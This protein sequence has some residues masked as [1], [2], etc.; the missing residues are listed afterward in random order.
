MKKINYFISLVFMMIT[1]LLNRH[2]NQ[3]MAQPG[4]TDQPNKDIRLV[5]ADGG[6]RMRALPSLKGSVVIL[7]PKDSTV[8]VLE[9]NDKQVNIGGRIGYW[10]KV[11]WK[12]KTGWVFGGF[13][14][15]IDHL[16]DEQSRIIEAMSVSF[17]QI[18]EKTLVTNYKKGSSEGI[19]LRLDEKNFSVGCSAYAGSVSLSGLVK[20]LP[21]P[22]IS[23]QVYRA[24]FSSSDH[25]DVVRGLAKD[26]TVTIQRKDGK[27][28]IDSDI[29]VC[30]GPW[31]EV[32]FTITP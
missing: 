21:A 2:E 14:A 5:V 31:N 4:K 30:G 12:E 22:T 7:I 26:F 29:A 13:L 23:V 17:H 27:I 19:T 16:T 18:R 8:Q 1:L 11:V 28:I 10:Y 32:E 24:S 6:L 20:I 3:I 15:K 25:G 9:K